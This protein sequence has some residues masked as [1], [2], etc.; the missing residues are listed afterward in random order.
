[1]LDYVQFLKQLVIVDSY[2]VEGSQIHGGGGEGLT[3]FV[4][5]CQH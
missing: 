2:I 5:L 3:A 4:T 1:M